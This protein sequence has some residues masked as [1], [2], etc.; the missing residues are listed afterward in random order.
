MQKK[1]DIIKIGEVEFKVLYGNLLPTIKAD[2]FERLKA[3]IKE[4]GVLVPVIMDEDGGVIDGTSC[5]RAASE[6]KHKTVPFR[7]LHGLS[8]NEKKHLA[9]RLNA[10][11]RQMTQEERLALAI[12]LRKDGL[13]LRQIAEMLNVGH[14]TVSRILSTVPDETV[15]LPDKIKGKDGKQRSAKVVSKP[16]TCTAKNI[17]EAK[18]AFDV[19]DG[20]DAITPSDLPKGTIDVKR[21]EK[22]GRQV[23][24]NRKRSRQYEDLE[25]GQAKLLL[26]DFRQRCS[27]IE[28]SSVD[29]C[30]TDPLY[31]KDALPVWGD[32]GELCS[33]KLKPGGILMAYSG[34][35]YLPQVHQMLGEHLTYLWTAAI[36]HSGRS[37]L[38]RAV[39]IHQAWK[40]VLVY[41][42]PPLRKYWHPFM[43][44]VSGGQEKEHHIYEQSVAEAV[45][46]IKAI[47]PVNG[48]LLDPMMGSGTT[49]V[50]GLH[51][52][53]GLTCI[54]C[55]IDKA[56]YSDAEQRV[57]E[58]V[59]QLKANKMSA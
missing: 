46:Y 4:M 3:S 49:I 17:S 6:L 14:A 31:E 25:M 20:N 58:T 8:E 59:E 22:I 13:S 29:L 27:E 23:E 7:I 51:A 2:E 5:L 37:K 1:L 55:E 38:V 9:I 43:D 28:D 54:G 30:F 12:D 48:V 44:M 16:K 40:P 56:A 35:L 10:Q 21:L 52:D 11:R 45:H 39:Q 41:Y 47:C 42:K 24:I 34:V 18:R 15:E 19:F 26:G 32:L 50:A 36:Y 33:R 57:K 53:L